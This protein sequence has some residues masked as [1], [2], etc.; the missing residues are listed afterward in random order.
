MEVS[1]DKCGFK[2]NRPVGRLCYKVSMAKN[3]STTQANAAAS[4]LHT[5]TIVDRPPSPITLMQAGTS[6]LH[7]ATTAHSVTVSRPPSQFST[8]TQEFILSELQKLSAHM[9]QVD[10]E[11][12][13]DTFTSTPR[14][15][16]KPRT[17]GKKGENPTMGGAGN[18]TDNQTTFE[19]SVI[20]LHHTSRVVVPVHTQY[21]TRITSVTTTSL[22]SQRNPLLPQQIRGS[23]TNSQ[24][25]VVFSTC[26]SMDPGQHVANRFPVESQVTG[27]GQN[28]HTSEVRQ[29]TSGPTGILSHHRLTGTRKQSRADRNHHY[30]QHIHAV[31]PHS[32]TGH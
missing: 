5:A 6:S 4:A 30:T 25:Q 3:I 14:K 11:F 24:T 21:S 2:H 12:Q 23:C 26:Q 17:G 20:T 1:C 16:K 19:E 7:T 15:R 9:S 31:Q 27:S 10:Q 13:T 18:M 22:F 8:R 29:V 28:I 32:S